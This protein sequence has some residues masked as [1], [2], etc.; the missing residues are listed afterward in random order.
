MEIGLLVSTQIPLQRFPPPEFHRGWISS[1]AGFIQIQDGYTERNSGDLRIPSLWKLIFTNL[2]YSSWPMFAV[3]F[4]IHL[5]VV[6]I[7]FSIHLVE[8]VIFAV[9]VV[10]V[11]LVLLPSKF[12]FVSPW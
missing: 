3:S 8:Q 2:W 9:H 6:F 12:R 11:L 7:S 4:A 5:L 1:F 10:P